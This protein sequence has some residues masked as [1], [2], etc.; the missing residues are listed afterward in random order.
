MISIH[1]GLWQSDREVLTLSRA[2][3]TASD[4]TGS[5]CFQSFQHDANGVQSFRKG[6]QGTAH[7]NQSLRMLRTQ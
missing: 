3:L 5:N 7:M 1:I 4:A 2:D 6:A